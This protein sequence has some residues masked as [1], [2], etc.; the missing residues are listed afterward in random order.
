MIWLS[1]K[2][3]GGF[4]QKIFYLVRLILRV[5]ICQF[6]KL[7]ETKEFSTKFWTALML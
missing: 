1:I 3:Q 6:T 4:L 2:T 7:S 5:L